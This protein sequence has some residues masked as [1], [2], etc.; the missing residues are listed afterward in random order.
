[1]TVALWIIVI[2]E[3]LR[4]IQNANQL[5]MM[6]RDSGARENA[7]AEFVKSLQST[8]KEFAERL[9]DDLDKALSK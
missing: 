8:D 1:M 9:K 6:R 4:V 7:Y 2:C 5:L 3:I